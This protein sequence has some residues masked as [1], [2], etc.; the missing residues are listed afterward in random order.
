MKSKTYTPAEFAYMHNLSRTTVW[1][2][3]TVKKYA[4][5]LKMYDAK[6]V[7]VEGR[8]MIEVS[9]TGKV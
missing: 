5:Y 1:R 3:M 7:V 6:V 4:R 9:K 2:Y 8:K